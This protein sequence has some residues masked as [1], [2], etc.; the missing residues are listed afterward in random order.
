MSLHHLEKN[1][2]VSFFCLIEA[3]HDDDAGK[4]QISWMVFA[5]TLPKKRTRRRSRSGTLAI[6]QIASCGP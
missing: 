6:L 1:F 3:V 5:S 2:F 4:P